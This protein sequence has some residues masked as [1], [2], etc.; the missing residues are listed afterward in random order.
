MAPSSAPENIAASLTDLVVPLDSLTLH[1]R[2]ARKGDVQAIGESLR[3]FGQLKPVVVQAQG[4]IV[5]AG[6]HLVRAAAALGW[7]H[8]AASVVEL[9]DREAEAYLLADNRTS[10]LGQ[11]DEALLA[12]LLT[13]NASAENLLGTG[14]ASDDVDRILAAAAKGGR[15][16]PDELPAEAAETYVERGQMWQLGRHR[17]GCGDATDPGDVARLLDGARPALTVSDAP[18]GIQYRPDQREGAVR[19][20]T[21]MNDDRA[22]WGAAWALSPSDVLYAW[23]AGSHAVEV[24][25][26]IEAAG[27]EIRAQLIWVKPSLQLGRGHWHWQ[28]EPC[29][30]AV[31]EGATAHWIGDRSQA[32]VWQVPNVHR[33]QGTSDD[34]ITA[35]GTQKPV[36]VMARPIRN[37]AGD[38]YDPFVGSGTTIIAAEQ[39]GRR[40]FAMDL[41]PAYVQLALERWQAFT[42]EQAVRV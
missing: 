20:G 19:R 2:N 41:D 3:R 7:Q 22:D 14:Y 38:V 4:R 8:V 26:G 18:Y 11:Y 32:T 42:G 29:W 17:L 37:H 39:L 35:H 12:Q 16:D 28:H 13:E 1:L 10:D 31:R 27:F 36:E 33:T 15:T 24:G 6:N 23:H 5:V 21:V 25:Q 30:Y 40:A 9:S 34:A